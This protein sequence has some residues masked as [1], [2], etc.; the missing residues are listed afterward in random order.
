M[1]MIDQVTHVDYGVYV[2]EWSGSDGVPRMSEIQTT[3]ENETY[4]RVECVAEDV[5]DGLGVPMAPSEVLHA[6]IEAECR[7]HNR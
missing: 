7:R 1:I 4:T 6:A 2:V 3:W 5:T